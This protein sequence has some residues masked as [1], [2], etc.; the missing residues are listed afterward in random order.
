[1]DSSFF[2]LSFGLPARA[3]WRPSGL[4]V[5]MRS[6]PWFAV[7]M[8]LALATLAVHVCAFHAS[9]PALSARQLLPTCPTSPSLFSVQGWPCLASRGATARAA[10]V[11][12]LLHRLRATSRESGD[13]DTAGGGVLRGLVVAITGNFEHSR[14]AVEEAIKAQGCSFSGTVHKR[15]DFLFCDEAALQKGTKHVRK[16]RKFG[17]KIVSLDFFSDSVKQGALVSPQPY[18]LTP[19]PEDQAPEDP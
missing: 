7:Q 6:P 16:A 2:F 14:P 11:G 5:A 19:P 4:Q 3:K 8:A 10:R 15:V 9:V 13:S 1:M 17:T 12:G 18:I